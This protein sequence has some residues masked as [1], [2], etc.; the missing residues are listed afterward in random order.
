[1]PWSLVFM[2]LQMPVLDGHQTTQAL[3][4]LPRF[5]TL[6]II[7]MTAHAL[8]DEVQRCLAE[9]MNHHLSKPIDPAALVE[10]LRRWGGQA[11]A[12]P[13]LLTGPLPELSTGP[14]DFADLDAAGISTD[15]G[16]KNCQGNRR[17]YLSLLE[18]FHAALLRSCAQARD[19]LRADDPVSAQRAMHTLKGICFNLGADACGVLCARAEK[20]LVERLSLADFALQLELL[21]HACHS[22]AQAIAL[23]LAGRAVPVPERTREAYSQLALQRVCQQLD[24]FLKVSDAQAEVFALEQDALLHSAFGAGFATL[25][26]QIELFEFEEARTQLQELA[27]T[28]NVVLD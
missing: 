3:R 25:L 10:S 26:A 11:G 2:D 22:L 15:K 17:L 20:A 24:G 16:L 28:V 9:G 6:P 18:K 5:D 4:R 1:L 8:Q 14:D 13:A 21:E 19:A 23:N 12:G 27:R 7:A